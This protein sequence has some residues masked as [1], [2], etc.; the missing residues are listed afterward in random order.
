MKWF[1]FISSIH[2]NPLQRLNGKKLTCCSNFLR[3]LQQQPCILQTRTESP[4]P[5]IVLGVWLSVKYFLVPNSRRG[6]SKPGNA[7]RFAFQANAKIALLRASIVVTYYIKLFRT[8]S[9]RHNGTLR[10]LLLLVAETKSIVIRNVNQIS[11]ANL[12]TQL[13]I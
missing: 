1:I 7:R 4:K 10:S 13:F 9:D 2:C 11:I 12:I 3:I 5:C 8:G 6:W